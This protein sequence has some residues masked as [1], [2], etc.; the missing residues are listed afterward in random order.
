MSSWKPTI[1]F[2]WGIT[3]LLI[4]PGCS[5]SSYSSRYN[6]PAQDNNGQ[7]RTKAVRFSSDDDEI[8]KAQKKVITTYEDIGEDSDEILDDLPEEEYPVDIS[9]LIQK[10]GRLKDLGDALT[11]R[12]KILFEIISYIDTPYKYG[13]N[14]RKGIDCSAF[15]QNVFR[16]TIATEVPR[17]AREQY[18][19]GDT[20][21][22]TANLKFGDLVFF[23]TSRKAYPGHVGIYIGEELFAHSSGGKGVTITSLADKYYSKRF[24]GG[25][26]ITEIE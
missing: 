21:S 13:G 10:H 5:S 7:K 15:T 4:V 12:E 2:L 11:D 23:N 9:S 14:T 1:F 17:T 16:K 18:K 26:R 8:P 22:D 6:K 3:I 24:I 25:K 19:V 20:I